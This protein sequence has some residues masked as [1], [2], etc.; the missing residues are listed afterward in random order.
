MIP[1]APE[2]A[3]D[4]IPATNSGARVNGIETYVSELP[5][6]EVVVNPT[7]S[8]ATTT[9]ATVGCRPHMEIMRTAVQK[10]AK[11]NRLD[12]CMFAAQAMLAA[13]Q[14]RAMIFSGL[15]KDFSPHVGAAA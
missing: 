2:V 3:A 4:E 10:K 13:A 6:R 11:R 5:S 15:G 1:V 7:G 9:W 12:E 14:T 8:V